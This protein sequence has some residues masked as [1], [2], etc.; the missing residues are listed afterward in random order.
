ML[1]SAPTVQRASQHLLLALFGTNIDSRL[2]TRD[3]SQAYTQSTSTISRPIYVRA[4]KILTIPSGMLLRVDRPLYGLPEAGMHW[5][6]TYHAH[7]RKELS[8]IAEVH[9]PCLLYTSECMPS[10]SQSPT[11]KGATCM[12]TDD[13]LNF[14]NKTFIDK[15]EKS[16]RKFL[17]KPKIVL[18]DGKSMRF[19]GATISLADNVVTLNQPDHIAKL[20]KVSEGSVDQSSFVSQ[21]ARGA[22]IASV[23]RPDLTFGFA[24]CSQVVKADK[25]A[26]RRLNKAID[27]A[28]SDEDLGL[29]FVQLDRK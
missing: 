21:R 24:V 8:M 22:Y 6:A 9:D 5:F 26:A 15:E 19:N 20:Q 1:T 3:I 14:G 17:C 10:D 4:P 23:C 12:Q 11:S 13:T 2:F 7:H 25:I 27:R 16:S 18:E 28:K 29:T